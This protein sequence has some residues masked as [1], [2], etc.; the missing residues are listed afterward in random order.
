M[1]T[2]DGSLPDGGVSNT[3]LNDLARLEQEA[4]LDGEAARVGRGFAS[5]QPSFHSLIGGLIS[6]A[7]QG[8]ND[9]FNGLISAL[10]GRVEDTEAIINDHS[11]TLTEV[12]A[13]VQRFIMQGL[14]ETYTTDG[15]HY[16]SEGVTALE[17][18]IIGAGAGGAGGQ[19]N[20]LWQ[21][22]YPGSGGGGGGEVHTPPIPRSL[23]DGDAIQIF[24]GRGG[25][26][27]GNDGNAGGGGGSSR[28]VTED[29]TLVAGGGQG[30]VGR[31][32]A[33]T[34]FAAGGTGMIPGGHGGNGG[35]FETMGAPAGDG[36][37]SY[38]QFELHGGGGGGGG[39]RADGGTTNAGSGGQ[40]GISPGGGPNGDGGTPAGIVATGGGGGGGGRIAGGGS[41]AYPA[42]G[43]G[44]GRAGNTPGAANSGGSGGNGIVFVIERTS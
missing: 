28:V 31:S 6:S 20:L 43:G 9:F 34:H 18:I 25:S 41:G 26:G 8:V 5:A 36:G 38:S 39:G 16:I 42:G 40:G 21:S 23:I 24:V 35:R 29:G 19:W 13:S 30:G 3:G 33:N 37:D 11:Q 15:V 10:T 44:G 1:T 14:A 4:W 17:F 32:G 12:E 7:I 27:G 2:P 22:V